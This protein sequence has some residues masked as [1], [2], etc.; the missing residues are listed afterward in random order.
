[1]ASAVGGGSFTIYLN[2]QEYIGAQQVGNTGGWQNWTTLTSVPVSFVAGTHTLRV[3][4]TG[5]MNLN[6][7]KLN[8]SN[9]P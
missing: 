3:Q 4:S 1:V 2:G 6:W 7:I 8:R 5:N 9:C